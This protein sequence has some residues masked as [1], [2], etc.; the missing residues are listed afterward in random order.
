MRQSLIVLLM[1]FIQSCSH[2]VYQPS[3]K[4]YVDPKQ[5]KLSYE[6]LY[7]HSK[8]GTK[9]HGWFFPAKTKKPKGTVVQFHGNAQNISTHF[10]S[11][12][13]LTD[14]G[15]NL[16]T[17]DYRGYAK[18]EGE[19]SQKG[20]YLDALSAIQ[21]GRELN[22]Q[23]G[24]GKL[25]LYGQSLGGAVVTRALPDSEFKDEVDLLVIDSS[26]SSYKEV[27]FSVMTS[28]W[29]LVPFSPLAYVLIS[30]EYGPDKVLRKI[31]SPTL[32]I[33]G[34]KDHIIPSKFGKRIFKELKTQ[35]KWLWKVPDGTHIDVFFREQGVYRHKFVELLEGKEL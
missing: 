11:L 12:L 33:V 25:I 9:L 13:W 5:Y 29:F 26:F 22:H 1:Y 34:E 2:L 20:L 31:S 28:R 35:K 17:F 32:V 24:D 30:N 10:F 23:H 19:S 3:S 15:Y 21:K 16:F 4:H 6:D 14:Q 27:S 7:F 8:D 18:S